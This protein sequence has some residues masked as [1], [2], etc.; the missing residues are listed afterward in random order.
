MIDELLS[1]TGDADLPYGNTYGE[2][3]TSNLPYSQR[4]LFKSASNMVFTQNRIRLRPST[5]QRFLNNVAIRSYGAIENVNPAN[6]ELFIGN[7][8][9]ISRLVSNTL[10]T[11][12]SGYTAISDYWNFETWGTWTVATNGVDPVQV[13]KGTSF[14]ALTVGGEFTYAKFLVRIGP[15]LVAANLSTGGTNIAWCSDDDIEDWPPTS[16]NTAGN[17]TIRDAS[18]DIL[19]MTPWKKGALITTLREMY[20][21]YPSGFPFYFKVEKLETSFYNKFPESIVVVNGLIYGITYKDY[22]QSSW[23]VS[24]GKRFFDISQNRIDASGTGA[25]SGRTRGFHLAAENQIVWTNES[26]DHFYVYDLD[27]KS[28]SSAGSLNPQFILTLSQTQTAL[29]GSHAT[30]LLWWAYSESAGFTDEDGTI[31]SADVISNPLRLATPAEEVY[32][33]RMVFLVNCHIGT[34]FSYGFT[35]GPEE[36]VSWVVGLTTTAATTGEEYVTVP[37]DASGHYFHF[38]IERT[39]TYNTVLTIHG[40]EIFGHKTGSHV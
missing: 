28:F 37:V 19:S 31:Y 26:G 38:K 12:G 36:T 17:Y 15:Y 18:S 34:V 30:K 21:I 33:D 40:H 5:S 29:L 39:P 35:E 6:D 27:G 10:S 13:H 16:A 7:T 24:D 32:V 22:E 9:S 20:Y 8:T 2:G 1:Q 25:I 23:W 14:A 3:I 4:G 11:V